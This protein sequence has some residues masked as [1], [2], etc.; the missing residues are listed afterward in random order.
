MPRVL[1]SQLG[2]TLRPPPAHCATSSPLLD[3]TPSKRRQ[4]KGRW[5]FTRSKWQLPLA[6][7]KK[8][9]AGS[10]LGKRQSTQCCLYCCSRPLPCWPLSLPLKTWVFMMLSVQVPPWACPL[11]TSPMS[12]YTRTHTCTVGSNDI[13]IAHCHF[14]GMLGK[15]CAHSHMKNFGGWE[16]TGPNS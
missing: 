4:D 8:E 3:A 5:H 6:R 14:V 9:K 15:S 11:P 13:P 12:P 16:E 10:G 1:H 7:E 2:P